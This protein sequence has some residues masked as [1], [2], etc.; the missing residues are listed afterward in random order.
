MGYANAW[1]AVQ[2]NKAELRGGIDQNR[3]HGKDQALGVERSR[4]QLR[5]ALRPPGPAP[6][7]L[8]GDHGRPEPQASEGPSGSGRGRV[9]PLYPFIRATRSTARPAGAATWPPSPI[10]VRS[11]GFGAAAIAASVSGATRPGAWAAL[12]LLADVAI[13]RRGSSGARGERC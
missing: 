10:P 4:R 11:I 8:T 3:R 2:P 5:A 6:T 12:R 13:G 1:I 9:P 7:R